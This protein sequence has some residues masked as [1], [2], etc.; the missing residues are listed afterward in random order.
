M[1]D[2]LRARCACCGWHII[3]ETF[4]GGSADVCGACANGTCWK[5]REHDPRGAAL[6]LI[7]LYVH[8]GDSEESLRVSSMGHHSIPSYDAQIR[9][10]KVLVA[11]V[12]GVRV[13]AVFSLHELY[14]ECRAEATT[15]RQPSLFEVVS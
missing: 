8:R 5:G 4:T 6:A 12:H 2:E 7:R 10:S 1:T 3:Y 15:G 14:V 9:Y 11:R 13:D